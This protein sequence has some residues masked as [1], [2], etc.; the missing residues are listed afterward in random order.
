M[1]QP[2]PHIEEEVTIEIEGIEFTGF[3]FIIPDEST[4]D[5]ETVGLRNF[6]LI[7][8]V[9]QMFASLHT[10]AMRMSYY[11]IIF[12]PLL[13]P[14]IIEHRSRKWKQVA[15]VGRH[16]MVVFFLLYFFINANRG[17]NLHVF[18][19]HFFWEDIGWL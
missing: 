12:I 17:D 9:I 3:A 11:Y 6:L 15:M 14:K 5:D 18:P 7:A 1:G 19:Y 4:L 8:F 16:I 2:H 10:L 13:L